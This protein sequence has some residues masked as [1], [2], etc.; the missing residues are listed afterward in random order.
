MKVARLLYTHRNTVHAVIFLLITAGY[1]AQLHVFNAEAA[2]QNVRGYEGEASF[3]VV[4]PMLLLLFY[5]G[6]FALVAGGKALVRG[7]RP[8]SGWVLFLGLLPTM[9][10]LGVAGWLQW[11]WAHRVI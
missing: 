4:L 1:I 10:L 11:H 3:L 2:A 8:M 9:L 6:A 7:S 5:S